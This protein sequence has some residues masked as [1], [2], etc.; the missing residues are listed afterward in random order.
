MDQ[1]AASRTDRTIEDAPPG[2]ADRARAAQA[3]Q[4]DELGGPPTSPS[5]PRPMA[6]GM[7]KGAVIGAVIGAVVLTPLALAPILDLPVVARLVICWIAGAAAG[8]TMGAVFTAG[9]RSEQANAEN[10]EYLYGEDPHERR[11]GPGVS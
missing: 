10:Q 5:L 1:P 4:M 2:A 11:Q 7:V 3:E 8:A 9:A 6:T